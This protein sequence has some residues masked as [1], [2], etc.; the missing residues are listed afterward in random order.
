ML[1]FV[2]RKFNECKWLAMMW[3]E[4]L[5]SHYEQFMHHKL[6]MCFAVCI[7]VTI[8]AFIES[9]SF[10]YADGWHQTIGKCALNVEY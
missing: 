4:R 1:S 9:R 10:I 2:P 8:I 5:T 7:Y 6:H 3:D